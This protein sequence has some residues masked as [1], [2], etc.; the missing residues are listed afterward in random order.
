LRLGVKIYRALR[1]DRRIELLPP[2]AGFDAEVVQA[3]SKQ[4]KE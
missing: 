1:I 2:P 3:E 4:L